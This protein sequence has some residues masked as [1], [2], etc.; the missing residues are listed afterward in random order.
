M[1]TSVKYPKIL[2]LWVLNFF[3][4]LNPLCSFAQESSVLLSPQSN[5]SKGS[6]HYA[7]SGYIAHKLSIAATFLLIACGGTP[8]LPD[9][10]VSTADGGT[11]SEFGVYNQPDFSNSSLLFEIEVAGG[12]SETD[13]IGFVIKAIQGRDH[14]IGEDISPRYVGPYVVMTVDHDGANSIIVEPTDWQQSAPSKTGSF[15]V[16][17]GTNMPIQN[18]FLSN[19]ADWVKINNVALDCINLPKPRNILG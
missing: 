5:F 8:P 11:H 4:I 9:G 18:V 3:I 2:L 6:G 13:P 7:T 10:F 19:P 17:A 15:V 1:I 16:T 12:G 14:A